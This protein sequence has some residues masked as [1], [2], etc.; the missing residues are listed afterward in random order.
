MNDTILATILTGF[1][2]LLGVIITTVVANSKTKAEI[3][4]RQK[5]QQLEID[6][7]KQAINKHN[8]YAISIPVI[9][10][11]LEHINQSISE[12]KGRLEK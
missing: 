5:A 11:E 10:N 8:D 9:K 4:I 3:E 6:E 1:F 12:I 7:L 2:T